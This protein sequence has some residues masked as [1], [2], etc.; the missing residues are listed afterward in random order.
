M[1]SEILRRS[2]GTVF[3]LGRCRSDGTEGDIKMGNST[4]MPFRWNEYK[5]CPKSKII[6]F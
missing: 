3:Y 5:K 2:I 1:S 4:K 6:D